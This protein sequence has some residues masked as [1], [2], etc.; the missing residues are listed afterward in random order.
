MFISIVIIIAITIIAVDIVLPLQLHLTYAAN[1]FFYFS[2]PWM[3]AP[4]DEFVEIIC[5]K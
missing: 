5:S 3:K 4:E 1:F 2:T